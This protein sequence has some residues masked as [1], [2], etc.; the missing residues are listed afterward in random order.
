[1]PRPRKQLVIT[2]TLVVSIL[3]VFA[4]AGP[5]AQR[6][7]FYPKARGLPP[8]IGETTEQL[9]TRLQAVLETNAPTVAKSLLPGLSDARISALEVE[10]G[11]RLSDDLRAFYRWH[12]G[13][14]TNSTDGLL[15]GQRFVP[16]DEIADGRA[17]ARQ[18]VDS[19]SQRV[20]FSVFT[21]HRK[22]WVRILDDGASDGYFYDPKRTDAEG[23]FFYHM[24]EV[25]YYVWFP[26]FRNF[27]AGTIECYEKRAIKLA[28]NGVD[29]EEDSEKTEKIWER[30]GKSNDSGK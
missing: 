27:L 3:V 5:F 15:P 17:L 18:H 10:G 14:P 4:L 25:R 7:F 1:M 6:S 9:L 13:M 30:F 22:S 11:F 29:L 23:A 20:A 12:N 21:G 24:A 26:S 19:A 28:T 2:L 16:L 8:V